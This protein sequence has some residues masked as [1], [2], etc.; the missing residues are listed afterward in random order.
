MLVFMTLKLILLLKKAQHSIL[1][2]GTDSARG[3]FPY[4]LTS[5]GFRCYT[6][7][8]PA[9]LLLYLVSPTARARTA[10]TS[11]HTTQPFLRQV[12]FGPTSWPTCEQRTVPSDLPVE[13]LAGPLRHP[14]STGLFR[15][16]FSLTDT[17]M[18][19]AVGGGFGGL[20]WTGQR[21]AYPSLSC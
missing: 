4:Y 6:T 17:G 8:K 12:V 2:P 9:V 18:D 21:K 3:T 1:T 10:H 13:K 14:L 11:W 16:S 5:Y 20:E 7:P 15:S 19:A